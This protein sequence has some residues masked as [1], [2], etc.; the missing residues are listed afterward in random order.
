MNLSPEN[1]VKFES[2]LNATDR[3]LERMSIIGQQNKMVGSPMSS[4][5]RTDIQLG[6]S[7]DH[8]QE[9]DS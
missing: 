9:T 5:T 6:M 8:M 4:D 2:P 1:K 3:T 7:G